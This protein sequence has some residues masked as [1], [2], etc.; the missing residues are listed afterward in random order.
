MG[1]PPIRCPD[2]DGVT[3]DRDGDCKRCGWTWDG[4]SDGFESPDDQEAVDEPEADSEPAEASESNGQ[5]PPA[6]EADR[7]YVLDYGKMPPF[8]GTFHFSPD[9]WTL[10]REDSDREPKPLPEPIDELLDD[11]DWKPCGHCRPRKTGEP[12]EEPPETEQTS[13]SGSEI[14]AGGVQET[15]EKVDEQPN[16]YDVLGVDDPAAVEEF[17]DLDW[18][19]WLDEHSF[20]AAVDIADDVEDLRTALDPTMDLGVLAAAVELLGLEAE[21]DVNP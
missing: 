16:P 11:D 1:E 6:D 15:D 21:V 12:V 9:C 8:G 17:A 14:R 2:C 3:V 7:A 19:D 20:F 4:E 13:T 5:D 10:N 18:P